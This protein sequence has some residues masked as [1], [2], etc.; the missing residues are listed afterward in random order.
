[1]KLAA[2]SVGQYTRTLSEVNGVRVTLGLPPLLECDV[3][4]QAR[5]RGVGDEKSV[6]VVVLVDSSH[7]FSSGLHPQAPKA[8]VCSRWRKSRAIPQALSTLPEAGLQKCSGVSTLLGTLQ[9]ATVSCYTCLPHS[10][11]DSL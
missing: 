4:V 6:C 5:E 9:P 7:S 3:S 2:S 10:L 1:M 11:C 8:E